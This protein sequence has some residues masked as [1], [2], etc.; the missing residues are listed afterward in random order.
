MIFSTMS[1]EHKRQILSPLLGAALVAFVLCQRHA[2]ILLGLVLPILIIWL[3]YSI[4][5]SVLN[6]QRRPLQLPQMAIWIVAVVTIVSVHYVRHVVTRHNADEIV[7]TINNYT[8]QHGHC[9]ATTD[10][11][12]I[13]RQELT[14]KLGFWSDYGCREG[15]QTF[16]YGVT[17]VPYDTYS[18]NFAKATWNRS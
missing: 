3:P 10:D 1:R 5:V 17:Y 11:I 8:A 12:G 13:T 16:F 6:P 9:P 4:G 18:Y 15:K 14:A 7:T 2:G